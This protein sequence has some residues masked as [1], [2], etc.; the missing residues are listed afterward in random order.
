MVPIAENF[1]KFEG[2]FKEFLR[3]Q[4]ILTTRQR[5]LVFPMVLFT[6]IFIIWSM[7]NLHLYHIW[8]L[9][10]FKIYLSKSFHFISQFFSFYII[11][12]TWLNLLIYFA[13]SLVFLIWLE[14][15]PYLWFGGG[16]DCL[17]LFSKLLIRD[18]LL[19]DKVFAG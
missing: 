1:H 17:F 13:S 10:F 7:I 14:D 6:Y 12:I 2:E 16:S 5:W 18:S 8:A 11:T 4:D 3:W 15:M 19:N 9:L